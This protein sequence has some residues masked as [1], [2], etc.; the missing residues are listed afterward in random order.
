[1]LVDVLGEEILEATG[2]EHHEI[3]CACV[4]G[5]AGLWERAFAGGVWVTAGFD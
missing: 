5:R 3:E 2:V 4:G 1:M